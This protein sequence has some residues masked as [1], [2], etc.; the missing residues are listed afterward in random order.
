MNVPLFS[1]NEIYKRVV[2][3]IEQ[4][5]EI[6]TSYSDEQMQKSINDVIEVWK[7]DLDK[8]YDVLTVITGQRGAGKSTFAVLLAETMKQKYNFDYDFPTNYIGF[9][10]AV[11]NPN[12]KVIIIDEAIAELSNRRSMSDPT[13]RYLRIITMCRS[14]NKIAIF[15]IP[16]LRLLEIFIR[17]DYIYQ[18]FEIRQRNEQTLEGTCLWFIK[19]M[20]DFISTD[21]FDYKAIMQAIK[22]TSVFPTVNDL[23]ERTLREKLYKYCINYVGHVK[24]KV[25]QEVIKKTEAFSESIKREKI[26]NEYK[27]IIKEYYL[28]LLAELQ[29][30]YANQ[31]FLYKLSKKMNELH[32]IYTQEEIQALEYIY[33]LSFSDIFSP[34]YEPLKEYALKNSVNFDLVRKLDALKNKQ[35]KLTDENIRDTNNEDLNEL[36]D[37]FNNEN[38]SD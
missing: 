19:N 21:A 9:I 33:R 15:L 13:V 11:E 16:K 29:K 38:E 25:N 6:R 2:F 3:P 27:E 18:W 35:Q 26:Q 30:R 20:N 7:K 14:K 10:R 32:T 37:E 36:D 24:Y 23:T 17:G 31:N 5:Q 22:E 34:D 12:I 8:K 1:R 4:T 28:S